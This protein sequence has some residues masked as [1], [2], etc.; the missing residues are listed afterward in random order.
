MHPDFRRILHR[1]LEIFWYSC[2]ERRREGWRWIWSEKRSP[3]S[4]NFITKQWECEESQCREIDKLTDK[5]FSIK[6]FGRFIQSYPIG[7]NSYV[8]VKGEM[9]CA[10]ERESG[11][12]AISQTGKATNKSFN[13]DI[14]CVIHQV[15][16]VKNSR[17]KIIH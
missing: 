8:K 12:K 3:K 11:R 9:A 1:K 17:V 2:T 13:C 6:K 14:Y 10:F 4:Q 7:L 5:K 16:G 15:K